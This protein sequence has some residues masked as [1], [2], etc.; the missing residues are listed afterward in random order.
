MS[1]R[2]KQ[3]RGAIQNVLGTLFGGGTQDGKKGIT[4]AKSIDFEL[5]SRLSLS[6]GFE[7]EEME[8]HLIEFSHPE[9]LGLC[10]TLPSA[11]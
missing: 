10:Q 9:F 11:W 3:T 1:D 7:D 2:R 8:F 6:K 5:C 4:A